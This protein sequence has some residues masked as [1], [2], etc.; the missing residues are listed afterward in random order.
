MCQIHRPMEED[1]DGLP[2]GAAM[3]EDD[4]EDDGVT[5]E[6][7]MQASLP[8]VEAKDL[9]GIDGHQVGGV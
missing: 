7:S 6:H 2:A 9:P 5:P 8:A 1:D 4:D 3:D